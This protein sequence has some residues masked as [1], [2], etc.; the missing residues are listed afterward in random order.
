LQLLASGATAQ[1]ADKNAGNG[2][3]VNVSGLTVGGSDARNYRVVASSSPISVNITP[4]TL[5][6]SLSG[7]DRFYD[8]STGATVT[9]ADDRISGDQL[10][11]AVG[12]ASFASRNA[13]SGIAVNVS[14]I[15]LGG[16]DAANYQLASSSITGRA[17]INPAPLTV[18]PSLQ[19]KLFGDTLAF[20]GLEF[21]ALGLAP[22][23]SLGRVVL[24]SDGAAATAAVSP[25]GYAISANGAS[26]GNF[27]PVNYSISYR[28]GLLLVLP[29]PPKPGESDGNAGGGGRLAVTVDPALVARSNEEF[30]RA[31]VALRTGLGAEDGAPANN[32]DGTP[33]ELSPADIAALLAGDGRRITLP[34]LQRLPLISLDPQLKRLMSDSSNTTTRP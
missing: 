16:A 15:R 33:I 22:G 1:L 27:D 14:G 5:N 24:T 30:G 10:S 13:G 20:S 26:G 29:Q 31:A 28:P 6:T 23:E 25:Q 9:L 18:T 7:A 19:V 8:G 34:A 11:L 3:A 4:R 2:K 12:S 21:G 17:N 32:R